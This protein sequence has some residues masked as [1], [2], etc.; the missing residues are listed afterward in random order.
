MRDFQIGSA[1][2][3][4]LG[5]MYFY[6]YAIL[7][8]PAGLLVDA[9]GV[10]VAVTGF[11]LTATFGTLYFASMPN[12]GDALLGRLLIGVGVSVVWVAAN[13]VVAVLFKVREFAT[14][15][16]LT[17]AMG[18][19]G[20]IAATAPLAGLVE[21][22]GWRYSF[23]V[24]GLVTLAITGANA[25]VLRSEELNP[26]SRSLRGSATGLRAI[27]AS[28]GFWLIAVVGFF[29]YGTYSGFQGLWTIPFLVQ[30]RGIAYDQ[31]S[32]L[33]TVS[34]SGF[35]AGSALWGILSDRVVGRRKPV[36]LSC[37]AASTI[38]W[39][40][41]LLPR[42]G[43]SA[44]YWIYL[45]LGIFSAGSVLSFALV[46]DL[47]PQ[48][49]TGTAVGS[50]N[51][52]LFLGGLAFQYATGYMLDV[53]GRVSIVGGVRVYDPMSYTA[54]MAPYAVGMALSAVVT[55]FIHERRG[56]QPL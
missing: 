13:K 27:V 56:G 43:T 16:G 30:A 54:A 31:A 38:V 2:L 33:V 32:A 46:R 53:Q 11:M 47:F 49:L 37:V 4:L 21:A 15:S 51:L 9:V 55:M 10:R 1:D 40:V 52:F 44:M 14:F 45:A 17:A 50:L 20:A 39:V 25:L 41:L 22:V 35:A 19:L 24:I 42:L 29:Y 18:S 8:I 48:R 5:S 6:P 3:G 26:Q 34:A 23:V 7:Q 36:F 12:F 28:R